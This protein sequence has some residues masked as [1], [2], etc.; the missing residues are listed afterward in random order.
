MTG[1]N[2]PT[3]TVTFLFVDIEG[4]TRLLARLG[5]Q[6]GPLLTAVRRTL[7]SAVRRAGGHEVDARAD[8]YLAA[9]AAAPAALQ[10]AVDAQRALTAGPWSAGPRVRVRM[11]IHTG[12][13]T[14]TGSGYVGMAVHVGAR[15][16]RV[17]RGGQVVIS[18]T[19]LSAIRDAGVEVAV[20][21]LGAHRLHGVPEGHELFEVVP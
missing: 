17:A 1:R 3:G 11:G 7:R 4:S 10:A 8:E 6:Y 9:F 19:T 14:L 15:I 12:R 13:P 5:D 21:P 20:G 2:L 18:E 16:A